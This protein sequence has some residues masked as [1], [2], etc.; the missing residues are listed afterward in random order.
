MALNVK[1]DLKVTPRDAWMGGMEFKRY[2]TAID[3]RKQN[4]FF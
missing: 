3:E 1:N 4:G 2:N